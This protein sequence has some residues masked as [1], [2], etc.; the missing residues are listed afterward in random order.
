MCAAPRAWDIEGPIQAEIFVVW[1]HGDRI[2]LTGPCGPGPWLVELDRTEHPVEVVGRIVRD[3]L[4]APLLVHSTSWRRDRDAVILTFVVVID[5]DLLGG[6]ESVP[7]DRVE[8]ARSE[9]T[10]APQVIAQSQVLEHA[11]RHLA[12]LATDDA[13]VVGVLSDGW[14]GA[15][16]RYGPG[17]VPSPGIGGG[18]RDG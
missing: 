14:K 5:S 10:T 9:A 12:W 4:G 7:V 6:M 13:V 11:L 1:L 16:S 2:E 18:S 15:L 3:V 8:L 17:A